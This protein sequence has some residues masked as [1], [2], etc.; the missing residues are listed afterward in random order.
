MNFRP[1]QDLYEHY[2]AGDSAEVGLAPAPKAERVP[3]TLDY[4]AN[5]GLSLLDSADQYILFAHGWRMMPS[6][7]RQFAETA[8]KRLYWAGYKGRFGFFSW[9]TEWIYRPSH[10]P[11]DT[12]DF[13]YDL[14]HYD[15]NEAKA[16]RTGPVLM[17]LLAGL[18]SQYRLFN[19]FAHSMGNVVVSEA[20]RHAVTHYS[21]TN[22]VDRYVASQAAEV[23]DAYN[24]AAPE[25]EVP[26]HLHPV[27][28]EFYS[29]PT[30]SFEEGWRCVNED[31]TFDNDWDIPPDRYS[32]TLPVSHPLITEPAGADFP[33]E[34][35]KP[36]YAGIA[37]GNKAGK[38]INFQNAL[39]NALEGW[40]LN[41]ATKPDDGVFAGAP[42]W[43]Y[44][45]EDA[46]SATCPGCRTPRYFRD[47]TELFW[48]QSHANRDRPEVAG[49]VI[50]ARSDPLGAAE[51]IVGG[52]ISGELRLGF[53]DSPYDHSAQFLS[54]NM[55]RQDYWKKLLANFTK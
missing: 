5:P 38:V 52:E 8:L 22:L 37:T 25:M 21:G 9:P 12:G 53:T 27:C 34:Q 11:E 48:D 33:A 20:L 4:A 30:V 32:Y 36:Y 49:Y 6:E 41:Q 31:S 39:D 35:R 28:G 13:L 26:I 40:R 18:R 44:Q 29:T 2:T 50:P 46:A 23:A 55:T 14:Q 42:D 15:R 54:N 10:D 7:R 47:S 45:S 16:R 51:G 1:I 43:T 19:I 17:D 3:E 24:P